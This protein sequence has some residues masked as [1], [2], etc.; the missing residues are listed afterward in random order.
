[1]SNTLRIVYNYSK[2]IFNL[3][4]I[5]LFKIDIRNDISRLNKLKS[6]IDNCGF[7]MIK[8]IQWLLPS[9]NLIY[10]GTKL[11]EIFNVYYEECNIHDIRHTEKLYY[12][13]FNKYIYEDYDIIKILGSGSIG[14]VYLLQNIHTNKKY[15]YKVIHPNVNNEYKVFNIFIN[16]LSIF[17]DYKKYI[18][19]NDFSNF[20]KSIKDQINLNIESNNCKNIYDL[21]KDADISIPKIYYNCKQFIIMEYLEGNDFDPDILGK[22]DSYKYL[23]LL[24]IFTNNTCLHGICHGDLHN[25]NW[26][27][28]VINKKIIIYDFGYVFK[29]DNVEYDIINTLISQDDK[30]DINTKFFKYYLDKSYNSDLDKEIIMSK[31]HHVLDEYE[32]VEPP[33]LYC[34]IQILMNFCLK[35]KVM[36]ST[37]CLNGMLLFL[38]LVETFNRVKIL[39]TQATYESY[40]TD[41]LNNCKA[42]NNMCPKLIE[43]CEMKLEENGNRGIMSEDFQR[44]NGLKKFM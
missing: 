10:P 37:T 14:Q 7:M 31:I 11:Y 33:K 28:D 25:G 24:I 35:N 27:I 12:L 9:Y 20:I 6:N 32:N 43:Y 18:P 39:E 42:N 29:M 5:K 30:R 41:I 15:A 2:L 1:M 13:E 4:Y 36:I 38:Q 22:Y 17:I 26:K 19:I 40:L 16:I 8:C 44:F 21:Y 3:G 34:Y 23:M